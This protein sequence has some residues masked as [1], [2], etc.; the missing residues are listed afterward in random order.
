MSEQRRE[1]FNYDYVGIVTCIFS[2]CLIFFAIFVYTLCF[3]E[4]FLGD[5]W[6]RFL[7]LILLYL[8]HISIW[9]HVKAVLTNPVN[10]LLK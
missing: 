1:W 10:Y 8:S 5:T 4:S 9:A 2:Y 6:G 7:E 3:E